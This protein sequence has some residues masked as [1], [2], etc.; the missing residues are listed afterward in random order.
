MRPILIAAV[1]LASGCATPPVVA[2]KPNYDFTKLGRVALI[3]PD[4]YPN[5]PGSGAAV[6]QAMEPYLLKAGY[7]LVERGQVDQILQEQSFSRSANV[8]PAT[9]GKIGQL[10]GVS[11]LLLGRVTSAVQAQSNTFVQTV[12]DTSYQPVYQTTQFTD[13][14]GNTQVR[15]KVAN[16]DVVTTNDQVPETY[17][18]PATI[19]FTVKLVDV[20]TG[21]VLWTGSVSS[22]GDSVAEAASSA[23]QNLMKALKKAWPAPHS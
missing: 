8:D 11:A 15:Q 9:A 12:Q 14:N 17:T 10:L 6:G 4:D 20:A 5:D 16:Y 22:D 23:A 1:L 18:T 21:E 7:D 13:R 19:A 2:I 3:D